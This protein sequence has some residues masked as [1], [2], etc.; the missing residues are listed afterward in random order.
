MSAVL[1]FPNDDTKVESKVI[2]T[3]IEEAIA[4][5]AVKQPD[6]AG[7]LVMGGPN[8]TNKSHI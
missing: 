8:V 3:H 5:L 7:Q 2:S 1:C 6:F 4:Q